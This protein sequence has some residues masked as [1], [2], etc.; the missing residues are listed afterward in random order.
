[1]G[2]HLRFFP[3]AARLALVCAGVVA[4]ATTVHAGDLSIEVSG[5]QPSGGKVR[6]ALYNDAANFL[7]TP[8]KTA[9]V[10][11][12]GEPAVL[13]FRDL[14]AGVYAVSAYQDDNG[15]NK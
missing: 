14:P 1:M 15:N 10:V 8:F 2:Q 7:A 12:S 9:E 11:A 3:H 13:V 5:H 4:A 6:A